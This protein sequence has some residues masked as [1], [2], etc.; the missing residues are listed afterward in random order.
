MGHLQ[1]LR[2]SYTVNGLFGHGFQWMTSYSH[3]SYSGTDSD[4][5]NVPSLC[6]MSRVAKMLD[7]LL[8]SPREAMGA[9]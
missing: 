9:R 7:K 5:Q 3:A 6:I 2:A 1:R 4:L 8:L